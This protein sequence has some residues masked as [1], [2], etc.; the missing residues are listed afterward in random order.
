MSNPRN[1][2]TSTLRLVA[3]LCL[4]G[5]AP[6]VVAKTI[7]VRAGKVYPVSSPPIEDGVV[8]V[9]DGLIEAMGPASSVRIPA[10]AQ[11]IHED[12]A[13]LFPGYVDL[14]THVAGTD[15]NDT[16]YP[17]NSELNVLTQLV[18][19]NQELLEGIAGG[20]TT[21]LFIPGSGSNLGGFG[22]LLKTAGEDLDEL[23]LRF[24]GAMKIAQAG[25]PERRSGETG[26]GRLGMNWNIRR[27]L[28]QGKDYHEAW[29]AYEQGRATHPPERI[30]RFELMRGLFRREFP[31]MVHTQWAPVFQSSLRILIDELGLWMVPGHS[32]FDS[33]HNAPLIIERGVAVNLGPRNYH[34]DYDTGQ[35]LGLA[36]KYHEEGVE[37]LSLN[38]DSPVI[39]QEELFMQ[40]TMAVRF[41]LPWEEAI[42]GLTLEPAKAIGIAHRVGSLDEGKDGDLVLWTGDPIDPRSSVLVV[43]SLGRVV[44][45]QRPGSDQARRF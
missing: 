7:V 29:V 9:T 37:D 16:V 44:L 26:R 25:N 5:L 13:W 17:V 20:V 28:Q 14:H 43:V 23:V 39:A 30:Q 41:G 18:P 4:L 2:M 21:S 33:F 34:V 1:C 31:V 8:V 35:F 15:L 19:G 12:D 3:L 22:A 11:V 38:T 32:T 27:E 45:D 36:A 10:G 6:A 42:A 24:P 40:G